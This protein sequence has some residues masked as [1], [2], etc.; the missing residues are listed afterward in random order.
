VEGWVKLYRVLL[1]KPIWVQS[2]TEQK[3]VLITVLLMAN[4][5]EKEW[6]WKGERFK[7]KP[8]QFISSLE[9]IAQKAGVSIQN[10]RTA[11]TKFEKLDFLTNV[12]TKTGRLITLVNWHVYQSKEDEAN[13][14]DNKDLTNDQ[15]STN[16]DLTTNKNDNNAKNDDNAKIDIK[17][18]IKN[19]TANETLI[20]TLNAFL[21]VRKKAKAPNTERAIKLLLGELDKLAS[22][23]E[24]KIAIVNQSIMSGWKSVFALKQNYGGG[25]SGNSSR[26][27]KRKAGCNPSETDWEN[28]G[29][30]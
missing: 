17:T 4:H 7:A 6:I 22:D 15:Q 13:K 21:D 27:V 14:D 9:N 20:D 18:I 24:T 23:D 2:T 12:S 3:A 8:G 30:L 25:K 10:V 29:D 16:K 28:D 5:Q 26:P 1:D 11:I 19:Y